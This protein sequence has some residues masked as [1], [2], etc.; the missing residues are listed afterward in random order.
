MDITAGHLVVTILSLWADKF[1]L[2]VN[3][4]RWARFPLGLFIHGLNCK[5]RYLDAP[6]VDP[7]VSQAGKVWIAGQ[8]RLRV[9]PVGVPLR[10]GSLVFY[11]L[12]RAVRR[13]T[14]WFPTPC[15]RLCFPL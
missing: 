4:T 13:R 2:L 6:R 15:W 12:V 5:L 10:W 3:R 9:L 11:P 8:E 1:L 14:R 7:A